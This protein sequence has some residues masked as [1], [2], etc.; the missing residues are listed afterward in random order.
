MIHIKSYDGKLRYYTTHPFHVASLKGMYIINTNVIFITV[1]HASTR[2][3]NTERR[4]TL[5][6][7]MKLNTA[8]ITISYS[9]VNLAAS[10]FVESAEQIFLH[11]DYRRDSHYDHLQQLIIFAATAIPSTMSYGTYSNI[12]GI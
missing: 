6:G 5:L 3:E 4:R 9:D 12:I 7:T 11:N 10:P 1:I 8:Q 2:D